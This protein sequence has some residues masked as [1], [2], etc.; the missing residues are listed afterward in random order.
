MKILIVNGN[1]SE[2]VTRS[3]QAEALRVASPDTEIV[4]VTGNFGARII[5]SRFEAAIA[6]HAV[7]DAIARNGEGM[8]GVLVAVSLDTALGAAR[9]ILDVPVVGM[10]E[11]ALLTACML[12]GKIGLVVFDQ[13]LAPVYE[14]LVGQYGLTD[15]LART[16]IIDVAPAAV[17]DQRDA[18]EAQVARASEKLALEDGAEVVIVVG[19]VA[20]GMRHRLQDRVPVPIVDGVSSGI[21]QAE[22]LV[23][24]NPMNP[25]VGSYATP[26]VGELTGLGDALRSLPPKRS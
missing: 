8:D 16:R 9:E 3:I 24:L 19:A 17:S 18:V 6:E 5:G 20:A 21:L 7:L 11:A 25:R 14:A 1:T 2:A 13:R 4:A 12:G 15:R 10:T 23:R 22:L 26:D